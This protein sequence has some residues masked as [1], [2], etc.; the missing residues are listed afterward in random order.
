MLNQDYCIMSV[1]LKDIAMRHGI[2]FH[3]LLICNENKPLSPHATVLVIKRHNTIEN[4]LA[5]HLHITIKVIQSQ[6]HR[7]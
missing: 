5:S 1:V 3:F 4:S 2:L 7:R 6:S